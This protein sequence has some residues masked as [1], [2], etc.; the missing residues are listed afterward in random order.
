MSP[1]QTWRAIWRCSWEL[2]PPPWARKMLIVS[3]FYQT[4]WTLYPVIPSTQKSC[5]L[6]LRCPRIHWTRPPHDHPPNL[7]RHQC[8]L[9]G[10]QAVSYPGKYWA[11]EPSE[12]SFFVK[13]TW[14]LAALA[15]LSLCHN[16]TSCWWFLSSTQ[17]STETCVVLQ[18]SL[19]LH[20]FGLLTLTWM[21]THLV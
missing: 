18:G 1:P 10:Y 13:A 5:H 9:R 7:K 6:F 21:T 11:F 16:S 12:H 14:L 8:L 3:K 4:L 20:T 19:M 15:V 17:L 2:W